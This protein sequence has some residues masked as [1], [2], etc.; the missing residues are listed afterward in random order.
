MLDMGEPVKI[1]DLAKD[2]IR[3]SGRLEGL[4][5]SIE[6]TG[7]RPG[8]K[9]HEELVL[10]EEEAQRTSI[11]KVRVLHN[12]DGSYCQALIEVE[13]RVGFLWEDVRKM[14]E[15]EL[16]EWLNSVIGLG[17]RVGS[18]NRPGSSG[19]LIT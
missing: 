3:L 5:A 16:R 13:D 17:P 14:E 11:E 2:M 10:P 7:L 15:D 4:D 9:L 19:A 1:M 18:L 6:I 12:G 8:E